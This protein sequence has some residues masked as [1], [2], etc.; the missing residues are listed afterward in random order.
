VGE[1]SHH[2]EAGRQRQ[3]DFWLRWLLV[4][5]V[6]QTTVRVCRDQSAK[7][8]SANEPMQRPSTRYERVCR[9]VV[10]RPRPWRRPRRVGCRRFGSTFRSTV[11]RLRQAE[12]ACHTGRRASRYCIDTAIVGGPGRPRADADGSIFVRRADIFFQGPA[13]DSLDK[14]CSIFVRRI[15]DDRVVD[16][17]VLDATWESADND[18][19]RGMARGSL[20]LVTR[21]RGSQF[22][23]EKNTTIAT[24]SHI[25][26]YTQ[27][28][29]GREWA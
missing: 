25:H 7:G 1:S 14:F 24:T 15:V 4:L 18:C 23:E 17:R 10:L 6:S 5:L 9:A 11:C 8:T 19:T 22:V 12:V 21:A 29:S 28:R 16:D 3:S 13:A 2:Q 26:T 27:L 20:R